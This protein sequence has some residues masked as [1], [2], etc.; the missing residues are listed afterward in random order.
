MNKWMNESIINKWI[1]QLKNNQSLH[2]M[3]Y[4]I[5]IVIMLLGL[6]D[7]KWRKSQRLKRPFIWLLFSCC[8]PTFI[9]AR[10]HQYH[11]NH[12]QKNLQR[13][14]YI[15][16]SLKVNYNEIHQF[17]FKHKVSEYVAFKSKAHPFLVKT[18]NIGLKVHTIA[19]L[20]SLITYHVKDVN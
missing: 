6:H 19:A 8:N 1:N 2:V 11:N 3:P 4:L 9:T 7:H 14:R 18:K 13:F 20:L 15:L 16:S 17:L 5:M 10:I 12:R